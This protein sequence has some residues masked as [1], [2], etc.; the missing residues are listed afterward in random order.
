[1]EL[2]IEWI[3]FLAGMGTG[4]GICTLREARRLRREDED[5]ITFLEARH[6]RNNNQ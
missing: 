3:M 6:N 5:R 2:L 1:M 4:I